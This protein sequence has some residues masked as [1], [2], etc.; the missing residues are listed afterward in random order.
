MLHQEALCTHASVG[1]ASKAPA[2]TAQGTFEFSF[3]VFS[4]SLASAPQVCIQLIALVAVYHL[5]EKTY[6]GGD[7]LFRQATCE[8]DLPSRKPG[9]QLIKCGTVSLC[10]FEWVQIFFLSS[11]SL[12]LFLT[13]VQEGHYS[14]DDYFHKK[15]T[16]VMGWY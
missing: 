3:A 4:F 16:L 9:L 11:L 6:S 5:R 10:H 15:S 12:F 7:L 14:T 2:A 8:R 13:P 1:A